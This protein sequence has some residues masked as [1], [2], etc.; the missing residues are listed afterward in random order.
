MSNL[1]L[2]PLEIPD[3]VSLISDFLEQKDL[4]SCIRVS[5]V[6]HNTLVKSI[7]KQII[8]KCDSRNP[9]VEALQNYKKY[10]EALVFLHTFPQEYTALQGCSRLR[11]IECIA[12]ISYNPCHVSNLIKS[13]SCTI[14][15]LTLYYV[16]DLREIWGTFLECTHLQALTIHGAYIPEDEVSLFFQVCKGL[17]CLDLVRVNIDQLPFDFMNNDTDMSIF[18]NMNT[19]GLQD[20]QI[21]SPPHP[22]TG[23]Y[24]LGMLTKRCPRLRS[25][26][27]YDIIGSTESSQQIHTEFYRTVFLDHP[28]TLTDLSDL[29]MHFGRIKDKDM[30]ALLRQMTELRRLVAQFCEFGPLSIRELLADE[31]EIQKNGH[32]ERKRREQRLCDTVERLEFSR[33]GIKSDG[34]VQTILSNCP[35]LKALHG[36]EVTVTEIV[37]GAEWVCTELTN[38]HVNLVVDVD[39]ETTEGK[40][41]GRIV[42]ERIR[43]LTRLNRDAF[44][45]FSGFLS[46]TGSNLDE[47]QA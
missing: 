19:L 23:S 45:R 13:H 10:I 24:C 33:E 25:L 29:S 2:N 8:I 28:F 11:S 40:E 37:G 9:T 39:Q 26:S 17:R 47:S 3:I 41:K 20:V 46:F 36:T 4:L 34:I 22:H 35:R 31:Q 27:F 6:F 43:K 1:N 30:A 32:I 5:K 44:L 42:Y 14:T 12:G 16:E 7:W 21:L 15:E 38:L 18:P